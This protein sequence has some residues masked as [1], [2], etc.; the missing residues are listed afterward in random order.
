MKVMGIFNN[1]F[2][3]IQ[4]GNLLLF[5]IKLFGIVLSGIY[6]FFTLILVQQV[7]TLRKVVII[8]NGGYLLLVAQALFVVASA[9]T[10]Y[11]VALL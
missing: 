1:L 11:A 10:L 9:L 6:L 5:F 2:Q 7:V 4:D 8:H 3:F